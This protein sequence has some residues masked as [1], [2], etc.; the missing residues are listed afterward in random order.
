MCTIGR[1]TVKTA[2]KAHHRPDAEECT[3]RREQGRT[4]CG[5]KRGR[6]SFL[7]T[8][9]IPLAQ[10]SL[11]VDCYDGCECSKI[12]VI[13][14][15]NYEFLRDSYFKY[16]LLLQKEAVHTP[17]K[18]IG[19]GIARLYDEMD[20][21]IGNGLNVNIEQ[22]GGRL[23]FRLWKYHKWGSFTLYYFPVKFMESLNPVLRRI[24]VTFL[25]NL[26]MA[27]DICT[28]L[29]DDETDY[30]FEVLSD[31]DDCELQDWKGHMRLLDSYQNGKINRLLKRVETKSYYKNLPKA[32]EAYEPR[33]GFEQPLVDAMKRGLPFLTPERGIMQYGYDAYYSE[34]PD[35][36]P[37]YLQQQ[38]R[39]VYDINDVVSD[40]LVDYYNTYSRETY[41]IT[42]VTVRDLSPDTEEL[43]NMDDY[44]ERFFR[45]ADEFISLIS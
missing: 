42:P 38:I 15:E 19:E 35:F 27:N 32:L 5:S 23:F 12:N 2:G 24:A 21:L 20:T 34:D 45:W 16:A 17:G 33:N 18:S 30:I 14:R 39:V 10:K 36:H 37:M 8:A 40:Y 41:D 3:V 13:T 11:T 9:L 4:D 6:N 26:M 29:D 7:N 31:G 28:I 43:F 44:P 22:E 1:T 25:H